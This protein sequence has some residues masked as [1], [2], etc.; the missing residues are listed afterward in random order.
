MKQT[1]FVAAMAA[2]V[3]VEVAGFAGSLPHLGLR[4]AGAA[5]ASRVCMKDDEINTKKV[6]G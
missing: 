6:A 5:R 1:A 2:A 4:R 3:A